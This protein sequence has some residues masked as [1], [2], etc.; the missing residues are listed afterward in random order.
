MG[1]HTFSDTTAVALVSP[2][3]GKIFYNQKTQLAHNMYTCQLF[4]TLVI[5]YNNVMSRWNVV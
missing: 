1:L 2:K 4:S 5:G 3:T